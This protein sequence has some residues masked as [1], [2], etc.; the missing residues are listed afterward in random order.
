MPCFEV[1]VP[2][3]GQRAERGSSTRRCAFAAPTTWSAVVAFECVRSR[4]TC[5]LISCRS[6][7]R[8]VSLC[9]CCLQVGG[10]REQQWPPQEHFNKLLRQTPAATPNYTH[11]HT[12]IQATKMQFPSVTLQVHCNFQDC[13][14]FCVNLCPCCSYICVRG[15]FHREC[16]MVTCLN[17]FSL[18]KKRTELHAVR[19]RGRKWIYRREPTA[20]ERGREEQTRRRGWMRRRGNHKSRFAANCFAK[21]KQ[22]ETQAA[23][24][25][26]GRFFLPWWWR[27]WME[28]YASASSSSPPLLR[29]ID[30]ARHRRVR[31]VRKCRD[32]ERYHQSYL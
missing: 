28:A 9:V 26:R 25:E 6:A 12:Q 17:V 22:V 19:M 24:K 31:E 8:V 21:Q 11:T 29:H 23:E 18:R 10:V 13:W 30:T 15:Q 2:I 7:G 20:G 27:R 14:Q 5:V 4:S 1:C 3:W 16:F 32:K